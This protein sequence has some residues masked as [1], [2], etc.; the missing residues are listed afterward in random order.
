MH[1]FPL[2]TIPAP[3]LQLIGQWRRVA[4]CGLIRTWSRSSLGTTVWTVRTS[5]T[6]PSRRRL[7]SEREE[8]RSGRGAPAVNGEWQI[9][10][11]NDDAAK[12]VAGPGER[13]G[14][15]SAPAWVAM[16]TDP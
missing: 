11:A 7:P 13:C 4:E 6:F 14:E 8:E 9:R 10:F 2:A 12:G 5:A 1:G 15:Q 16:R 3:V